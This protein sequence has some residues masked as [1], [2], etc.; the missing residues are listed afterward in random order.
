MC[1]MRFVVLACMLVNDALQPEVVALL[2]GVV[3][4]VGV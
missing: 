1:R 4:G 2:G 3:L